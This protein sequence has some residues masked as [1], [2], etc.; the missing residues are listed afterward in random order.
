MRSRII[1]A[2]K[3]KVATRKFWK[4]APIVFGTASLIVW[5]FNLFVMVSI[6]RITQ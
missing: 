5:A 6:L 3:Q 1:K 4:Y 2:R